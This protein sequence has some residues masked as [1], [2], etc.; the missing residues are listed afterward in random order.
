MMKETEEV[1]NKWKDILFSWIRFNIVKMSMLSKAIF[2]F[3]AIP[4]KIPKEFLTK[5]EKSILKFIQDHK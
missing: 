2:K 1:T 3:N 5:I 4:I